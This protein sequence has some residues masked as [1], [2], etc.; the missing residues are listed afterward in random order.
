[1][2]KQ[3]VK[4]AVIVGVGLGLLFWAAHSASAG[5]PPGY[6]PMTVKPGLFDMPQQVGGKIA[7][8]LPAGAI[9]MAA[10]RSAAALMPAAIAVPVGGQPMLIDGA[11]QGTTLAFQWHDPSGQVQNTAVAIV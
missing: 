9:W 2:D 8:L 11:M 3:A 5:A 6:A 10:T 1:V 4:I 7:F